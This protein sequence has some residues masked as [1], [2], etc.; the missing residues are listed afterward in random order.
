MRFKGFNNLSDIPV[1]TSNYKLRPKLLRRPRTLVKS[2]KS[3]YFYYCP[4]MMTACAD[5][6]H[7]ALVRLVGLPENE[8]DLF[9]T[10]EYDDEICRVFWEDLRA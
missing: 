9:V 8:T 7:G 2:N 1:G 5:I 6:P 3:I 4:S 10:V